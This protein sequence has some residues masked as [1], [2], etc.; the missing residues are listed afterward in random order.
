MLAED[1]DFRE[2]FKI[3]QTAMALLDADLIF[4][5]VNDQFMKGSGRDLEDLVGR[6]FREVFPRTP[7]DRGSDP[8]WGAIEKAAASGRREAD[9]LVRYDIEDPKTGLL[10]E[11]YFSSRVQPIRGCDGHVE[12]YELSVLEVTEIVAEIRAWLANDALAR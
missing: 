7:E 5:D 12:V 2:I 3:T 9:Q 4:I 8:N 6:R 11:R 10:E 1:L